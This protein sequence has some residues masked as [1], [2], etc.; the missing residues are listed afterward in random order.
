METLPNEILERIFGFCEAKTLVQFM[1]TSQKNN[2]LIQDMNFLW[3]NKV[4]QHYKNPYKIEFI[5]KRNVPYFEIFKRCYSTQCTI[6]NR[7]TSCIEP[8]SKARLCNK[9]EIVSVEYKKISLTSAKQKYFLTNEDLSPLRHVIKSIPAFGH[10]N[11]TWYL[12]KD[13]IQLTENKY[14]KQCFL[15]L[16]KKR[17]T[18]YIHHL[19]KKTY[20]FN[21]LRN[22]LLVTC[23][24]DIIPFAMYINKYSEGLYYRF[25]NYKGNK[26]TQKMFQKLSERV[27]ELYYLRVYHYQDLSD[28][29][30]TSEDFN[31][32]MLFYMLAEVDGDSDLPYIIHLKER[33]QSTYNLLFIRKEETKAYLQGI[34]YNLTD[35]DVVSYICNTRDT[36]LEEIRTGYL[37]KDY[38]RNTLQGVLKYPW[39]YYMFNEYKLYDEIAK[40]H[41]AGFELPPFMIQK[42]IV[43][44]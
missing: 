26:S 39:Y 44:P 7:K 18:D 34:D 13:V 12:E 5:K 15:E 37:V 14:N 22:Y 20:R 41:E 42:Y 36:T 21:L 19:L 17:L 24:F 29:N 23:H 33:I 38:L 2:R 8:F 43:K 40:L 9:C 25:L 3:K 27:I 16:K 11:S 35:Y 28:L 4:A 31:R 32:S 1:K 10:K 6:C 30:F